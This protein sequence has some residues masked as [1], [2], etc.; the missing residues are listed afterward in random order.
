MGKLE[1][2]TEN[3]LGTLRTVVRWSVYPFCWLV[4]ASF[5]SGAWQGQLHWSAALTLS[6]G[7]LIVLL[8]G[9]ELL[10]PYQRRWGASW[11]S[12]FTDLK[13]MAVNGAFLG[14]VRF[15]LALVAISAAGTST[16]PASEWP[17]WLQVVSAL[18]IFEA[19][20][21]TVHRY[22]HVG[23]SP[24]GLFLWR[25]HCAHHLPQKLY[26][27]MHVV[28]HPLNGLLIQTLVMVLPIWFMGYGEAAST[29]FFMLTGMHGLIAHFNVDVRMGFM[30]YLFVG[31]ELHRHHHSSALKE[32]QNFGAVL[33]IFDQLF[34]TFVYRPG[35]APAELGAVNKHRYP[36]YQNLVETLRFPFVG[37][38]NFN[39]E[40]L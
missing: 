24:V 31:T 36:D 29:A 22:M 30:N 23:E 18:V 33:S 4:A 38:R 20:Q 17:V 37:Y 25:L 9:T 40:S 11:R 8:I 10:I 12:F 34:G 35:D 39:K 19:L 15:G 5:Y 1:Q 7:S 2:P 3:N 32:A 16:G 28:G 26:V 14:A 21:Y 27:T 13:Y 6:N